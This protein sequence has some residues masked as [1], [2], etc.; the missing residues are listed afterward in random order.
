MLLPAVD[1]LGAWSQV[2]KFVAFASNGVTPVEPNPEFLSQMRAV[3]AGG[4]GV[5]TVGER[6]GAKGRE[7]LLASKDTWHCLSRQLRPTVCGWGDWDRLGWDSLRR[8]EPQGR[9]ALEGLD[10]E[11]GQDHHVGVET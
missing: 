5:I 1:F 10:Q 3:A 9:Q 7:G 2:F 6:L 8:E 11:G 4:K